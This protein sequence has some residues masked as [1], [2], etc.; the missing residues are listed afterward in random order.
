MGK[1]IKFVDLSYVESKYV[2]NCYVFIEIFKFF[3][4]SVENFNW[5]T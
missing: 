2:M 4:A 5:F 1:D 3:I